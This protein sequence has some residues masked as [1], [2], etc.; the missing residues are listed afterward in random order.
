MNREIK[1]RGKRIDNGEWVYGNLIFI[2]SEHIGI[3]PFDCQTWV[4]VNPET[5]GQ[6]TG[7]K[8]KNGKEIYEG[9]LIRVLIFNRFREII[10]DTVCPVSFQDG[11]FGIT[12]GYRQ[13]FKSFPGFHMPNV[14]FEVIG[15]L[16]DT[17][18]LLTK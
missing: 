14:T 1:F 12:H 3:M 2:D 10:S 4:W 9:D 17:P 18:E 7:L 13:E 8:D 15:N 11:I 6:Y 16:H 5:V